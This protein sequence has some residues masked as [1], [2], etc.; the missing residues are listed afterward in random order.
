[1]LNSDLSHLDIFTGDTSGASVERTDRS[2]CTIIELCG[3]IKGSVKKSLSHGIQ[4]P[5]ADRGQESRARRDGRRN[6][7][8]TVVYILSL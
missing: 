6:L 5:F 4:P 2:H 7:V 3:I 1:M 8:P